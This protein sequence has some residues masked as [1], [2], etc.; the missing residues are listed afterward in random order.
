MQINVHDRSL[1][2]E[3]LARSAREVC[4][5]AEAA[6]GAAA[7]QVMLLFEAYERGL[8]PKGGNGEFEANLAGICAERGGEMAAAE[9]ENPLDDQEKLDEVRRRVFG[10]APN[11]KSRTH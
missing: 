9:P 6:D 10:S 2:W 7:E 11:T 4:R 3:A 5:G 1:E 8:G